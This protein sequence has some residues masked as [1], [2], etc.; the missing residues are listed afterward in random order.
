MSRRR[1]SEPDLV[2]VADRDPIWL[3]V[4]A[5]LGA[6]HV[7][8]RLIEDADRDDV[9]VLGCCDEATPY[10]ITLNVATIIANTLIHEALHRIRPQWSERVV[11][12]RTS[13]LLAQL[14]AAEIE[15]LYDIYLGVRQR[16]KRPVRLRTKAGSD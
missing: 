2:L 5:A 8:E 7:H 3:E 11:R 15:R 9:Y 1:S 13:Q 6:G 14:S 12:R 4:A 16:R 10:T